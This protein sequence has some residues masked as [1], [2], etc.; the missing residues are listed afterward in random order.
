MQFGPFSEFG[1]ELGLI[2]GNQRLR[3]VQLFDKT[4][5]LS[6]LTLIREQRQSEALGRKHPDLTAAQ[7][8]GTWQG[9]AVTLYPDWQQPERY[10]TQLTVTLEGN[11]LHQRL[12]APNLE[13]S[14]TAQV[15]G[16]ILRFEQGSY[17]VQILLL[18]GGASS[19]TPLSIPGGQAFSLEAGWLIQPDLRQRLIRRYDQQGGWT[20]LTLVT[21][22][23]L[24]AA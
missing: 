7:L 6:R 11:R 20:S 10:S 4:S 21:E 18:P 16:S 8:V 19:N 1:A 5:Q 3:L 9:E 14:S 15:D 23:K 13:L 24:I 2:A 17:P 12:R 22:R